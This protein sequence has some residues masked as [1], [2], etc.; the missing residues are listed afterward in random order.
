MSLYQ[1]EKRRHQQEAADK[2][3]EGK[4]IYSYFLISEIIED[5][6][7]AIEASA[8]ESQQKPATTPAYLPA[9]TAPPVQS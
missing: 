1:A 7:R 9:A 3:F 8:A 6:K 2:L 4:D 5:T